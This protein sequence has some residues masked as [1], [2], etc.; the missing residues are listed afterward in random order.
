[1]GYGE[2]GGTEGGQVLTRYDINDLNN[3]LIPEFKPKS[4]PGWDPISLYYALALQQMGWTGATNPGPDVEKTWTFSTTPNQ[5]YFQAA[6]HWTTKPPSQLPPGWQKWW[7][8]CTHESGQQ[9]TEE[10][11]LPWHRAYI[12]WFEV[13]IRSYVKQLGGPE[14]WTL[15]YWNYSGDYEPNN[16]KGPWPRSVLP[17]VFGQAKLPDNSV[18]PLF[19]DTSRR[20]LQPGIQLRPTTPYYYQAYDF[21]DYLD[22]NQ[23]LDQTIHGAV[24]GDTGSGDGVVSRTGWMQSVPPAAFDPI[25]FLHHAEI[26]RFWVGW[27]KNVP[28]TSNPT[29][30][31]WLDATD[32]PERAN[33]WNFWQDGNI[34]N[35]VN[36]YPGQIQDNENMQGPCPYSYKYENLP[37]MPPPR[38]PGPATVRAA[39]PAALRAGAGGGSAPDPTLAASDEAVQLGKEPVTHTLAVSAEASSVMGALADSPEQAPHVYLHLDG[40][41]ADGPPGNYEVYLNYPDADYKTEGTVPHYV[42]VLAGFGAD[43]VHDVEGESGGHAH[44]L[45]VKYDVTEVVNHLREA[46]D[47]DES[48]ATVTFVPAFG[49]PPE[50]LVTDGMRV[51]NVS[52]KSS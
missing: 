39:A 43:H 29:N 24:H 11:F 4:T 1:M 19:L 52:I 38:P 17:W 26:D 46:G 20:G 16:P 50:D 36:V 23:T 47:W 31:G 6:M 41:T 10:F 14:D 30:S 33:R 15:P 12:Y 48:K 13:L 21:T 18:N 2:S 28:G 9:S 5:Y 32:D 40:I 3:G 45:S 25:F 37:E 42:G 27:L 8:H 7:D 22:F 51:A 35:V 49:A 34:G 44:G